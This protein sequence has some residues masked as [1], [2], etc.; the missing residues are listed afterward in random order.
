MENT[1]DASLTVKEA[2]QR[3]K[4]TERTIRDWIK[5]GKLQAMQ[6]GRTYRIAP[7]ALAALFQPVGTSAKKGARS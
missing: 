3:C 5:Q 4:V 1:M 6:L 7:E 2:A